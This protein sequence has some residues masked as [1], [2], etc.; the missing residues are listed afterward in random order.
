MFS[1]SLNQTELGKRNNSYAFANHQLLLTILKNAC[2]IFLTLESIAAIGMVDLELAGRLGSSAQAAV[3]LGDQLLYLTSTAA[4]GLSVATCAIAARYFG[5]GKFNRLATTIKASLA[6]AT[7]SGIA[8]MLVG[9]FAAEGF[10]KLLTNDQ[11]VIQCA[12]RYIQLCAIGSLPYV[13]S[14]VLSSIFRA[15]GRTAESLYLSITTAVLAIVLSYWLFCGATPFQGSLDALCYAWIGGAYIGL[16]VGLLVLWKRLKS[17]NLRFTNDTAQ[18]LRLIKLLAVIGSAVVLADSSTLATDFLVYRILSQLD[19]ATDMQAAW[20]IYLKV[21]E[22]FAIMPISAISL[23][24]AAEVGQLIGKGQDQDARRC[25]RL[26]VASSVVLF[27]VAGWAIMIAPELL[28]FLTPTDGPIFQHAKSFIALTPL[29][30]PLLTVRLILFAFMEG[31]GQTKWPMQLSLAGNAIKL[32]A[33]YLLVNVFSLGM[34]GLACAILASRSLMAVGSVFL[35]QRNRMAV[36][37]S[38]EPTRSPQPQSLQ[39]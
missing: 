22:T 4:A 14:I 15:L 16:I 7:I 21:E 37:R 28:E 38:A 27:T 5:A 10:V 26:L 17:L 8:A 35:I 1:I 19:A 33:G 12:T 24:F 6:V 36:K 29:F 39:H 31:A 9:W 34:L 13:V 25:L 11:V 30:F 32:S 23:A 20:T 3:G 2:P 18:L